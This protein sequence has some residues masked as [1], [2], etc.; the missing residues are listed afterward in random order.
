[1]MD[2]SAITYQPV[3]CNFAKPYSSSFILFDLWAVGGVT[4]RSYY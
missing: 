1:M 3:A 4:L 2:L